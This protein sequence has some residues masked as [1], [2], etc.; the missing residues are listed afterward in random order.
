MKEIGEY[1]KRTRIKNGVSITEVAEDL[2]FST[3]LLENIESGNVRAF[4]DVYELKDAMKLYAKYL[5]LDSE[6]VVDE[7]NGFLFQHTSK[8]SL[9]DIKAAQKKQEE[10]NEKKVKSPYTKEYKEKVSKV[11]IVAVIIALI[12]LILFIWFILSRINKAPTRVDELMPNVIER[13]RMYEFT[14]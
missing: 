6:K 8:I 14:N 13:S 1:L 7:F 5:G 10:A 4:K 12:I 9:E 11:P 2:D 3:T